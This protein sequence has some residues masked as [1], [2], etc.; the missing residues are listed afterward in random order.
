[1]QL[2][3]EIR[4]ADQ[5]GQGYARATACD[6][7]IGRTMFGYRLNFGFTVEPYRLDGGEPKALLNW[8]VDLYYREK[9]GSVLMGRMLADQ[10]ERPQKIERYGF[11][12]RR[13]FDLRTDEFIQLAD[14]SHRGDVTFEFRATPLLGGGPIPREH[15]AGP[16]GDPAFRVAGTPE[17]D[18]HG[19]VRV[20]S[21]PCAG[22]LEPSA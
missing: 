18:G 16:V 7:H 4:I 22:G 5:G 15:R 11:N 6:L 21:D 19:S 13:Y 12:L 3:Q 1:M 8:E 2:Q 10:S 20:G 14:R 17:P 9:N